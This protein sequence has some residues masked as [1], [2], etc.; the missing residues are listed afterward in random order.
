MSVSS[1]VPWVRVPVLSKTMV[2]TS[3]AV[4]RAAPD[5][6]RMPRRA[7]RPVPTMMEVGTAR[8]MA[9]GQAMTRTATKTR[10][11]NGN[12]AWPKK[13]QARPEARAT[14]MTAGTK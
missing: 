12:P 10:R 5:L 8:P 13:Y 11:E 14:A 9:Q 6:T 1:G 7:P 4:W 2:A 3:P